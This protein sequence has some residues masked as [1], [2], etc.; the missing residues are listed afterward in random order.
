MQVTHDIVSIRH[1]RAALNDVA[2]VPTMG[3]LHEGHRS[4]IRRAHQIARHVVVSI[5]VNPTQFGPGEDFQQYPRPIE[6]DLAACREEGVD[7]VFQPN[8]A[9]MYPTDEMS[10]LVDVPQMTGDLEGARR[11][12]HFQGVCRVCA[13]LFSIVQPHIAC[14]GE[15]DY[16]QLKVIQAMVRGL[17]LPMTI[18]PCP[19]LRE[20]DG[21]AM[22]SRNVYLSPDDRARALGLSKA[23]REAQMLVS[24]GE[25][26]PAAI[27]QAMRQTMAAHRVE[28][29]YAAV[30]DA[31]TLRPVDLVN[32]DGEPVVCLVAGRVDHVR[33]I[34]NLVLYRQ[35]VNDLDERRAGAA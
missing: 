35:E 30:R 20:P 25:G 7:L 28:V 33:L 4:L 27:E 19:T 15:K 11:P 21:L 31:M 24:D 5:F 34:D 18:E 10:V 6:K 23:L 32:P 22:S 13:K 29:D 16:Q 26:D 1:A 8:E 3:A 2:L 12:G 9:V 14:F 17:C